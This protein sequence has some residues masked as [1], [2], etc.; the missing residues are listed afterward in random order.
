[1]RELVC[2]YRAARDCAGH[3]LHVASLALDDPRAAARLLAPLLAGQSVETFGVACLSARHRLLAWH[4]LSRGTRDGTPVSIPDVFLPA[5][6]TP[7]TVALVV[8]HNHPSGDPTPSSDDVT[9]TTRL[10]VAA[11]ILGMTLLDHLIV[12]EDERYYSFCATGWRGTAAPTRVI[13]V[14]PSLGG[15]TSSNER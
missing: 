10:R 11:D 7:G 5:C 14:V 6:V 8:V 2:T 9:L 1:V 4:L 3:I 15:T 13:T 12:A